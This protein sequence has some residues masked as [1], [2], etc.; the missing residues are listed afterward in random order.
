[1]DTLLILVTNFGYLIAAL[2][3][4]T[5][6]AWHYQDRIV[7]LLDSTIP[8]PDDDTAPL[9]EIHAAVVE[10]ASETDFAL[11]EV[12]EALASLPLHIPVWEMPDPEAHPHGI[13]LAIIRSHPAGPVSGYAAAYQR[14][15]S[16][17][18]RE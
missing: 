14:W 17:H 3:A 15:A 8:W 12:L 16:M 9:F 10:A 6:V 2:M 5:L 11:D 18:T 7:S 4:G 1:M 13:S